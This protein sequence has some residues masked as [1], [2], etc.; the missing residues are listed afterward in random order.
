MIYTLTLSPSL[1]YYVE[2]PDFAPGLINRAASSHFDF[3][4]K[5]LN[6]ARHLRR[7]D[8]E[9]TPIV[10]Y[11][12]QAG[13]EL[14]RLVKKEGL[15]Y[16][17]VETGGETRLNVK[18]SAKKETALN[19]PAP[20]A[21]EAALATL[22]RTFTA[23]EPGSTL[24]LAGQIGSVV[25]LPVLKELLAPLKERGVRFV[26]DVPDRSLLE[27]LELRP[28]LI[29]PN[30]E[31]LEQLVGLR[32][33]DEIAL[34][35]ALK[36]VYSHGAEQIVVSLGDQG[37]YYYSGWQNQFAVAARPVAPVSTVGAGDALLAAYLAADLK[38]LEPR[39]A[40]ERA[41]EYA[42]D[43]VERGL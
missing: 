25:D 42:T 22:R 16:I 20:R 18:I 34:Q 5:G 11:A 41:V 9:V 13:R 39:R 12:G 38:G 43:L 23:I 24:V 30:F 19:L 31:E 27:L 6:V 17:G 1:D 28:L 7:L 21:D 26:F 35:S 40:L 3:G 36:Y 2:C 29:K 33:G 32:L 4:G 10:L 15:G 37:A 8:C 14:L